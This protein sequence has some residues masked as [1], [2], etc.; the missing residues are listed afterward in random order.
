MKNMASVKSP[1]ELFQL[2]SELARKSFDD[3]IA[4]MSKTS[5]TMLKLA[6]D[7]FQPLSNRFAVAADKFKAAA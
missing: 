3:M 1:T 2:Q 7:V 6:G 4:E 5:E